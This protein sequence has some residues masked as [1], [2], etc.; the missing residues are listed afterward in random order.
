MI[1]IFFPCLVITCVVACKQK[2]TT[3][4]AIPATERDT[5]ITLSN[6]YTEMFFDSSELDKFITSEALH[7]SAARRLRDF[8]N[9][10]N[11]QFAWFLKE[12]VAPYTSSFIGLQSEYISY[13]GDSS[14]Y[15]HE[16]Q[17]LYD[18]LSQEN[19]PPPGDTTALKTEFL[20][21]YQ[22]FRYANKAYAGQRNINAQELEWYIPRKKIND[23]ALLDSLLNN[24]GQNLS[25]FEPVNRQYGLIKNYLLKYYAI[26]KNGGWTTINAD[27]KTYQQ[28]D[29]SEA[30]SQIKRRLFLTEDLA[31]ND[32]TKR[33]TP[34]LTE[35]IKGYQHRYGFKETGIVTA[36]LIEEMNRPVQQRIRQ[37]LIN[38]ERIRWVPAE[39]ATDYLL[40]NIPEFRLHVYEQGQYKWTMNVVTGSVANS[41]VIFSGSLKYIVFSPY[42]NV[43]ASILKKEVLPGIRR[44]KNYLAN[45]NMEWNNGMVRQKPGPRNSLGL[46][47]FLFPNSYSIYFHDT[48]SKS[49]FNEPK[50]AFSHGCIRLSEPQ[51][52]AEYLLRNDSAWNSAKIVQAMHAQKE[53]YVTLKEDIPVVIGYFTA[54]VDRRGKLNFR[55]DIYGH[56]RKM[57][58]RLFSTARK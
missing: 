25:R 58:E 23:V 43:P 27:R 12:G 29:S 47:K 55:E 56:D 7:D 16:L 3:A 6:S 30:I 54:W 49:L 35:A 33:F 24:K 4:K 48:P 19:L 57:A 50:R 8:Y 40:V 37:M 15:N 45:H 5:S 13:S 14:L 52:L 10:R 53:R 1:K 32:T 51:K 11:F 36:P 34:A 9:G 44:N 2:S 31:E 28:G 41:T 42:W 18:S 17:I 39:P 26:E 22:F 20:L 38:M 46:V 21:T